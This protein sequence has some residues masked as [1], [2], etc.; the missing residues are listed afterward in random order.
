MNGIGERMRHEKLKTG[1]SKEAEE[2][3]SEIDWGCKSI[4]DDCEDIEKCDEEMNSKE[5]KQQ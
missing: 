5:V 1:Y 3:W 2:N 4:C